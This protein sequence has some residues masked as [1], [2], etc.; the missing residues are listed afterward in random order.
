MISLEAQYFSLNKTLL[1]VLGLW[2]YQ[3]SKLVQLQ[4]ILFSGILAAAIIFQFTTF[5]T[6]KCTSNFVI[7][8]LSTILAF[9]ILLTKYILF[10]VHIE[11]MKNLLMKLQHVCNGLKERNEITIIEKYGY[12]AKRYTIILTTFFL[13]AIFPIII[14]QLWSNILDVVLPKNESRPRRLQITME[15]FLDQEKYFYLFLLHLNAAM[16][17]GTIVLVGIVTTFI[18]YFQYICGMF[19][20]AS[21]RI[22][23][24]MTINILQDINWRN[25]K[26]ILKRI[27][28]AVNIHRQAMQLCDLLIS[29][30]E[31]LF[32]CLIILG[33]AC[34]SFNLLRRCQ[35]FQMSSADI[36]EFIMPILIVPICVLYMFIVNFVGQNITD[37]N[38]HVYITAYSVHWY[39]TPVHIQKLI[40]FLLRKG[41]KNFTL[42]I[43]GLFDA[44]V[45]CFV[46]LVKAS[47]SYFTVIY[48]TR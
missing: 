44:S 27:I 13:S 48:S 28:H 40:L 32:F 35:I 3:Q 25:E 11:T 21:Y 18:A 29:R 23:N 22:E 39:E 31:T 34:L 6:S 20:I 17:I 8:G 38:N 30:F 24:A 19:M 37:H 43:G 45:E 15:Y 12:N 47:V 33:V 4:F 41:I 9:T 42:T 16:L 36:N 7:K 2:P 26:L 46:T 10:R 14:A 1:R 5:I